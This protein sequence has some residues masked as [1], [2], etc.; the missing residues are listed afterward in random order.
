MSYA[1]PSTGAFEFSD[2]WDTIRDTVSDAD[3]LT[4]I[5][6]VLSV[7]TYGGFVGILS[8]VEQVAL[9]ETMNALASIAV[10]C[11][12]N[13]QCITNTNAFDA[14]KAQLAWRV[15]KTAEMGATGA[16]GNLTQA[17][18]AYASSSEFGAAAVQGWNAVKLA[19]P[20]VDPEVQLQRLLEKL[21]KDCRGKDPAQ[22]WN[23]RPDVL[24]LGANFQI[25]ENIFDTT[26]WDV[27][28]GKPPPGGL[29]GTRG[30]RL[31]KGPGGIVPPPVLTTDQKYDRWQDL[32]KRGN[33]LGI[34]VTKAAEAQYRAALAAE[35]PS[36]ALRRKWVI[37][38]QSGYAQEIV[39]KIFV[40]W[41]DQLAKEKG[42]AAPPIAA[43]AP[44]PAPETRGFIAQALSFALL[45][46]PAWVPILAWP[47]WKKRY[48][49]KR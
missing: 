35:P 39:D 40:Q 8:N 23:C 36:V 9:Q 24:A 11:K 38:R 20:N 30:K 27:A 21:D 26:N 31:G 7:G 25:G 34:A 47:W 4:A 22:D 13:P 5:G 14:W 6:T 18:Q 1:Y 41:V 15:K 3:F 33:P 43:P 12:G 28:T 44:T 10:S 49:K 29:G 46:S 48:G 42:I 45:T 2:I 16:L 32:L 17:A 37:A 19:Y